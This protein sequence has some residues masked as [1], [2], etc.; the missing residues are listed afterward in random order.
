MWHLSAEDHSQT[1]FGSRSPGR[2]ST[3]SRINVPW[4]VGS[5]SWACSSQGPRW[6]SLGCV[7]SQEVASAVP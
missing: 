3:F 5:S 6:V 2:C 1:G 7:R 4:R